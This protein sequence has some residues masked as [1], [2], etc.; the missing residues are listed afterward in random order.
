ME[1]GIFVFVVV[2]GVV[3]GILALLMPL[4]VYLIYRESVLTNRNLYKLAG[5]LDEVIALQK[6]LL[7]VYGHDVDGTSDQET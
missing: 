1:S 2:A 7:R 6:T 3:L 5:R 4:V